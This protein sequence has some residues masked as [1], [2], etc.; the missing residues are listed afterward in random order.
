MRSVYVNPVLPVMWHGGDYNPDQ[1]LDRPDILAEDI[2]LMKEARC[3]VFSVGIFSWSLLEPEEGV[4]NFAWLDQVFDTFEANGLYM[5]LATPSAGFPPWLGMKYPE[6][7][8]VGKDR[9]RSVGRTRG[10]YCWT[11]PVYRQKVRQINAAL[12]ER[13]GGRKAL[14]LWHVSNEACGECHCELCQAAFRDFLKKRH[15]SLEALNKAWWTS[16]S[17]HLYTDWSQISSPSPLGTDSLH[18]PAL[19]WNRFTTQ[20]AFSFLENETAPLRRLTPGVPLITN[21]VF[22]LDPQVIAPLFDFT[23]WDSYPGFHSPIGNIESA[24][25]QALMHDLFRSLKPG[26][27]FLLMESAPGVNCVPVPKLKRPGVHKAASL[28]AVAAG[29]DG[30]L[31]FQW[32]KCRG[33]REKFHGAVVGHDGTDKT[34][35]FQEVREVGETLEKLGDVTGS[36]VD[37][38]AAVIFDWENKWAL[39]ESISLSRDHKNYWMD[40][41]QPHHRAFFELGVATDVIASDASFDKHRM[42]VAPSLYM[43]KKGVAERLAEFVSRGGTLVLT[44]WSGIVDENDLCYLGGA[45][46]PLRELAGIWAEEIDVLYD[47]DTNTLVMEP[48]NGLALQGA[49]EVKTYCELV[50]LEGAETLA[51]YGGDYYKGCPALTVNKFGSGKVYYLA[52]QPKVAF[53]KELYRSLARESRT[54]FA[55]ASELPEGLIAKRRHSEKGD[56]LF[57]INFLD[58]EKRIDLGDEK[59]VDLERGVRLSGGYSLPPYGVLCLRREL[60]T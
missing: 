39:E 14:L 1:W 60:E 10:A 51:T 44:F 47:E 38:R 37:A 32:R 21:F 3:N 35:I 54:P 58:E 5:N 19:D 46:G 16:F 33:A 17:S 53:L 6:I 57:L 29:S 18:G 9:R 23:S 20:Q 22:D 59:W 48:G 27:P 26:K 25:H 34:R 7:T 36:L 41:V 12:A 55:T 24:A 30:V 52:T 11:S 50:R 45:P 2:K 49:F 31:Y 15:G 42:I 43:V 13:Y 28:L 56:F 8:R 40:L 4:Y